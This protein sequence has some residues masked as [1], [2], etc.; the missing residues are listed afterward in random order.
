ML[1][2]GLGMESRPR[3]HVHGAI[4]CVLDGE[5]AVGREPGVGRITGELVPVTTGPAGARLRRRVGVEAAP[6]AQADENGSRRLPQG[7]SELDRIVAGIEEEPKRNQGSGSLTGREGR[8]ALICSAAMTVL[9][10]WGR[11]RCTRSGAVQLSRA[12]PTCAI[13]E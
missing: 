10:S 3:A 1:A 12:K 2:M 11:K 6:G 7:L 5:V 8:N 9:F 4:L 13:Q